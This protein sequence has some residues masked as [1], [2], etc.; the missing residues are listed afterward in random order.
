M[1]KVILT[2]VLLSLFLSVT[3]AQENVECGDYH[4]AYS[5]QFENPHAEKI[6]YAPGDTVK[7]AF[8][9]KGD[10]GHPLVE[11]KV[12]V[13][14]LWQPGFSMPEYGEDI[15]D[16]FFLEQEVNLKTGGSMPMEFEWKIPGNAKAGTYKVALYFY[17]DSYNLGGFAYIPNMYSAS[18]IFKVENTGTQNFLSFDRG[19][20]MVGDEQYVP[21]NTLNIEHEPTEDITI[22]VPLVNEGPAT[23]VTVTYALQM[24]EDVKH[25]EIN[26]LVSAGEIPEDSLVAEELRKA[27][28]L[29][30]T[31]TVSLP[32]N[33]QAELSYR[34]GK[35]QPE[36][37]AVRITAEARDQKAVLIIRLPIHGIKAIFAY[38]GIQ[39]FPLKAGSSTDVAACFSIT[40][41]STAGYNIYLGDNLTEGEEPEPYVSPYETEGTVSLEVLDQGGNSVAI[42][43]FDLTLT[44]QQDAVKFSFTADKVLT[45][46]TLVSKIYD[47][48]GKLLDME[49]TTYDYSRFYGVKKTIDISATGG[50]GKLDYTVTYLDDMGGDARGMVAVELLDEDGELL[51]TQMIE[52]DGTETG[53]FEG[54]AE[55]DYS[56]MVT[57]ENLEDEDETT[58]VPVPEP[59]CVDDG[60]CTEEERTVGT[61]ADCQE[62]ADNTVAIVVI[63][64]AVI[65]VVAYF[66]F[67]KK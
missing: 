45:R 15:V 44:P 2:A 63:L 33:G 24:W 47:S 60:V 50:E 20:I 36:A 37:Y 54:L 65:A 41:A 16:E 8:D 13:Q 53:S 51:D 4:K 62:T 17:M 7:L 42:E 22:T 35:L 40:T 66:L 56:V 59:Q 67:R 58:V 30:K 23:T 49:K 26:E 18:T 5:V 43:E 10:V 6:Q 48:D 64:V 57:A 12:R 19:G 61:C 52:V 9:L 21:T 25:A 32:A 14:V 27:N 1:K 46:A 11:G 3:Y 34:V 38:S 39:N 29:E 31:D 55:G 28:S